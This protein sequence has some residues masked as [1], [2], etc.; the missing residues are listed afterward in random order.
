MKIICKGFIFLL[1]AIALQYRPLYG[2]EI[3]ATVSLDVKYTNNASTTLINEL[4]RQISDYINLNTWTETKFLQQEKVNANFVFTLTQMDDLGNIKASLVVSALR[5]VYNSDYYTPL[6]NIKDDDI[7][8]NIDDLKESSNELS[9][10]RNN[11]SAILYYYCTLITFLNNESFAEHGGEDQLHKLE[12]IVSIASSQFDWS[13]WDKR[14]SK[15][16]RFL[17]DGLISNTDV[18]NAF[19]NFWYRYHRLYL[20]ELASHDVL[21]RHTLLPIIKLLEPI[22]NKIPNSLTYLLLRYKMQEILLM[23]ERMDYDDKTYI[24][25]FLTKNFPTLITQTYK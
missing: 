7:A 18:L 1:T 4:K 16:R 24:N 25:A 14:L 10:V 3:K 5:P 9:N 15:S 8:F 21:F 22:S 11:L 17:Y 19:R 12:Q 23:S 20:D 2:Q 6:L 13:G